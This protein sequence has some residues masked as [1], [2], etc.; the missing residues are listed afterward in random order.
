LQYEP[1]TVAL[2]VISFAELGDLARHL[3]LKGKA[4]SNEFAVVAR[5]KFNDPSDGAR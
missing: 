2:A 3:S 1:K 5:V 4:K